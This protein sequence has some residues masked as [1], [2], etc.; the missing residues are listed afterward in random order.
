VILRTG[1]KSGKKLK[2][3]KHNEDSQE[4]F[5]NEKGMSAPRRHREDIEKGISISG[6]DVRSVLIQVHI[7]RFRQSF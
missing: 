6:P 2:N 4:L 1:T 5:I 3:T 7:G